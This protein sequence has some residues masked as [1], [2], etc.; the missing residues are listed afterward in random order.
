M[1]LCGFNAQMLK[2]L[3]MFAQGLYGATL[4]ISE[5]RGITIEHAMENEIEEMNVFLAALDEHYEELRKTQPVDVAMRNLV[6]WAERY[7]QTTG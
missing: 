1:A 4:R 5:K 2:G 3:A 6:K 7:E